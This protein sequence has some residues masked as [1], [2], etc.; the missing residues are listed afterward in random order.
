MP[1]PWRRHDVLEVLARNTAN[2]KKVLKTMLEQMPAA[3]ACPCP[4]ALKYARME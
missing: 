3:R 4:D 2:V 1:P